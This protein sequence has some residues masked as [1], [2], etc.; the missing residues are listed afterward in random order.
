MK[1]TFIGDNSLSYHSAPSGTD[2]MFS[3]GET[4]DVRKED[5]QHFKSMAKAPNSLFLV[6]GVTPRSAEDVDTD[7]EAPDDETGN[8][9]GDE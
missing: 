8:K 2:Y 5:A 4:T 1:V 7:P 9:E 3:P 6:K